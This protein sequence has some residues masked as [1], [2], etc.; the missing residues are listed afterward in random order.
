MTNLSEERES[1]WWLALGPG[2]FM[3]HFLISYG[4]VAIWCAKVA[5]REAQLGGARIA[6]ILYTVVALAGIAASALRAYRRHTYGTA[7]APHDFD[8]PEDRRR[9]LGFASLLLSGL[10]AVGVVY[11]ALPFLFIG[12]CR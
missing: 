10:S 9:F 6:V 5:G 1:L 12:S 4:T 3:L 7:T 8:T 11:V 2:I